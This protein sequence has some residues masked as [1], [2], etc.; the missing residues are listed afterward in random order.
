MKINRP[1]SP[2]IG[3]PDTSA[4]TAAPKPQ[5]HALSVHLTPSS[6]RLAATAAGTAVAGSTVGLAFFL[7]RKPA[8]S[9]GRHHAKFRA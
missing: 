1:S 4:E 2:S 8:A 6:A 7:S 9:F 3:V 5:A